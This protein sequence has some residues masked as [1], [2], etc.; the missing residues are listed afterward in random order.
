MLREEFVEQKILLA[1]E[2][3]KKLQE[4]AHWTKLNAAHIQELGN[5]FVRAENE[6]RRE[7]ADAIG[8]VIDYLVE[9]E[10]PVE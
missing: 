9:K 5:M 3:S 10:S 2:S 4:R 1:K 8:V 6:G 7:V